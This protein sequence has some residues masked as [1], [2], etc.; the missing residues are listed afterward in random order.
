MGLLA[1]PLIQISSI[2]T[3]VSEAFAG[4]DRIR[5]IRDMPTEDQADADKASLAD[6]EGAIEFPERDVRVHPRRAGAEGRFV[7]VA[8]GI[9]DGARRFE[10][11]R[12]EHPD[13]PRDGVQSAKS[14]RVLVTIANSRTSAARLPLARRRRDQDN[15]LF[16]GT[17]KENIAFQQAGCD[18]REVRAAAPRRARQ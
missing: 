3:Q 10:R 4:L 8:G 16:D 14:G 17:V 15:F 1:A 2:G 5:E 18:G 13:W 7:L 6:I 9:D 11:R 12:K